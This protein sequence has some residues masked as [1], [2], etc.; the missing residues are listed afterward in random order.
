LTSRFSGAR[1]IRIF[2]SRSF[3]R[4]LCAVRE[5]VPAPAR[6]SHRVAV[7]PNPQVRIPHAQSS[8]ELRRQLDCLSTA[9][10]LP[11]GCRRH[12][13][14]PARSRHLSQ[15]RSRHGQLSLPYSLCLIAG[16]LLI[17]RGPFDL[18]LN[19]SIFPLLIPFCC[20][21]TPAT[22]ESPTSRGRTIG[23]QTTRSSQRSLPR[24][25]SRR[26]T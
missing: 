18:L 26:T 14:R 24:P 4:H 20:G 10:R 17:R 25:R 8:C 2:P 22:I 13:G 12:P 11:P 15:H 19:S 5:T 9:A 16:K 23:G 21:Y 6:R 7:I 3:S 1:P